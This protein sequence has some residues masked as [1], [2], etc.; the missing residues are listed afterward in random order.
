MYNYILRKIRKNRLIDNFVE[1]NKKV[2]I[3]KKRGDNRA[4]E[5]LNKE[6]YLL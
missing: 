4:L 5:K 2:V 6:C 1:L 3:A